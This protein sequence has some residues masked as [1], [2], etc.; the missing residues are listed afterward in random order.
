MFKRE[1]LGRTRDP[2][3]RSITKPVK[4]RVLAY[5]TRQVKAM[6][7][8]GWQRLTPLGQPLTAV[9]QFSGSVHSGTGGAA[10]DWAPCLQRD[11][12]CGNINNGHR[13]MD[14][15]P[16]EKAT[17]TPAAS[18]GIDWAVVLPQHERWLRAV[19]LARVKEPQA[20]DEVLQEVALSAVRQHAPIQDPEKVGP[21]LYRL[22]VLTSLMY[23][24][25]VGRRKKWLKRYGQESNNG[26]AGDGNPLEWLMRSE[27]EELV[28]R[29]L[30]VLPARDAELL[31]LKYT[32]DWSYQQIADHLGLSFSAVQTRLHR[33]RQ[34]LRVELQ[35]LA[36]GLV[37]E[38]SGSLS[39]AE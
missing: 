10:A 28:R 2:L 39:K 21:W 26:H 19:I 34:R 13:Q 38:S 11:G 20:V 18:G 31:F 22:A 6:E 24:R 5:R 3:K 27:R 30:A 17:G 12:S 37:D 9:S 36:R 7:H 33:A 29:A 8:R 32:Q 4:K 15:R 23:R 25:A 1:I 16:L 14:E 35:R